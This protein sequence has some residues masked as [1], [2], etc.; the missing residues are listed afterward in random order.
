MRVVCASN[1]FWILDLEFRISGYP[2]FSSLGLRGERIRKHEGNFR[3]AIPVRF[4]RA[5]RMGYSH[6]FYGRFVHQDKADMDAFVAQAEHALDIMGPEGVGLGSDYDGVPEDAVMIV[7]EPSR[8]NDLWEALD[9]AGLDAA[10]LKGI[11]HENFLR[12]LPG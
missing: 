1:L 5:E 7:P 9:K 3:G 6:R 10:T 8:M 11:A 2:P 4:D 12:L